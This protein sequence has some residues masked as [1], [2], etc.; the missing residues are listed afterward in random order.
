M[1]MVIVLDIR[2]VVITCIMLIHVPLLIA[3]GERGRFHLRQS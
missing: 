3:V 2:V 1:R